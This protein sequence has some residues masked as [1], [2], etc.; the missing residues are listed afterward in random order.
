MAGM[1]GSINFVAC[2]HKINL[3]AGFAASKLPQNLACR[4][5]FSLFNNLPS[6]MLFFGQ[7][8][9]YYSEFFGVLK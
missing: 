7:G 3:S 9:Q 6:S 2:R 4:F 8:D 1:D 5:L